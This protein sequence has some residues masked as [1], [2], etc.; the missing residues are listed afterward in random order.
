MKLG[1][2]LSLVVGFFALLFVGSTFFGS[3]YSID[4]SERGVLL[5]NGAIVGDAPIDPGL[6]FKTPF[7]ESVD[8]IIVTFRSKTF[9]SLESYSYDQQL[10]DFRISV[11]YHIP[12]ANVIVVRREYYNL[13]NLETR[14]IGTYVPK[15]LKEVFGTYTASTAI[16]QRS[17][18]NA[19]FLNA[20]KTSVEN[21]PLVIDS[22]QIEDIKFSEVYEKSVEAKQL[23]EVEV[24]KLQNQQKQ[25]EVNK[26]ITITNAEA[27]AGAVLAAAQA[28]AQAKKLV[29]EAEAY[30]IDQRGKALK[31]NPQVVTLVA[32][33]KWDGKLPVSMP[34][35]GTVPF[36]SL[37]S[38]ITP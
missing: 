21:T 34:P 36:I 12:P 17:K 31:D 3:W 24:Q 37:P 28:D 26:Q 29:G 16:Q 38:T 30:A 33:E 22:V 6:H 8:K 10:A 11:N 13:D 7:I 1:T 25:A 35:N 14:I 27:Q 20:L 9:E 5:R 4:E 18:L 19:D 32:A 2:I 15:V 23:A